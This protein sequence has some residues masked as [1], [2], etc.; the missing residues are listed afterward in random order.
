MRQ[1]RTTV[2][3]A[4]EPCTSAGVTSMSIRPAV[5][6]VGVLALCLGGLAGAAAPRDKASCEAQGGTW[7]RFGVYEGEICRIAAPDAGKECT[8]ASHCQVACVAETMTKNVA[9]TGKCYEWTETRGA[10]LNRIKAGKTQG[11]VCID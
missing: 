2:A 8:D 1:G 3:A 4:T 11:T 9:A 7:G 6:M 5:W 10:C